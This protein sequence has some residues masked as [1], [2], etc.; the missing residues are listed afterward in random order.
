MTVAGGKE[1]LESV[2]EDSMK[3]GQGTAPSE[4]IDCWWLSQEQIEELIKEY[5]RYPC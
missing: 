1:L 4:K 2:G 3:K 5:R